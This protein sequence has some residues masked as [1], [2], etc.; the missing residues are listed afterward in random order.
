MLISQKEFK[1]N[2]DI[3][4]IHYGNAKYLNHLQNAI[5]SLAN[6]NVPLYYE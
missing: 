5:I 1:H 6:N 3:L 2:E 4:K